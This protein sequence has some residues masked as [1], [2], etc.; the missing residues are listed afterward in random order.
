MLIS[1]EADGDSS[2]EEDQEMVDL[3]NEQYARDNVDTEAP[4]QAPKETPEETPKQSGT[5][6]DDCID[7]PLTKEEITILTSGEE[8]GGTQQEE[9]E[10]Q[11]RDQPGPIEVISIDLNEENAPVACKCCSFLP[12]NHTYIFIK[13]FAKYY[14]FFLVTSQ[15]LENCSEE[16]RSVVS[17]ILNGAANTE[18]IT[19]T[20]TMPLVPATPSISGAKP[21]S[22]TSGAKPF[23]DPVT[24]S[25]PQGPL[26]GKTLLLN[27][28]W[29]LVFSTKT[30]WLVCSFVASFLELPA[31]AKDMIRNVIDK[32]WSDRA[33]LAPL[34]LPPY[35]SQYCFPS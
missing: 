23:F 4:Q 30:W 1:E 10:D 31:F 35:S 17:Q 6:A 20:T 24:M 21:S 32:V 26:P 16:I 9:E 34:I 15:T 5:P 28:I 7:I 18:P 12:S 27:L 11:P 2:S 14:V 13:I 22:S 3:H 33:G 25:A 8:E 29:C 19:M